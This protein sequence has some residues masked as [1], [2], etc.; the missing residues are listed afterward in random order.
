MGSL[1]D[2]LRKLAKCLREK[3]KKGALEKQEKAAKILKAGK[4]VALLRN[5]VK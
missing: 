4:G 3:G 5:K 1:A 2:D